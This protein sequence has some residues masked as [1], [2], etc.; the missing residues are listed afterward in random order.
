MITRPFPYNSTRGLSG[1]SG[2]AARFCFFLHGTGVP[3]HRR[4]MPTFRS[5]QI[6][7][8]TSALTQYW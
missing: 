3:H 2:K 1:L 6:L 7:S 4:T 5:F 8:N